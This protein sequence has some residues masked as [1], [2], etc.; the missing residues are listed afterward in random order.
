MSPHTLLLFLV[1]TSESENSAYLNDTGGAIVIRSRRLDIV[2][3]AVPTV[4]TASI[5]YRFRA[6]ASMRNS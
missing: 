1:V 4:P 3:A 2:L 6:W 5:W